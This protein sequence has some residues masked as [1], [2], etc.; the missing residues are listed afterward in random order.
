MLIVL[1]ILN[2]FC[3]YGDLIISAKNHNLFLLIIGSCHVGLN[4]YIFI[5]MNI[6]S[7]GPPR[8]A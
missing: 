5:A 7:E 2:N 4:I 8:H 3:Y 6:D 1:W